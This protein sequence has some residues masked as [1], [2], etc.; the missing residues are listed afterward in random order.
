MHASRLQL[1]CTL[2][3]LRRTGTRV[4]VLDHVY[5]RVH[6]IVIKCDVQVQEI[7]FDTDSRDV[8]DIPATATH[9]VC[10]P[11]PPP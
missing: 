8:A 6:G 5:S 9:V 10:V 4:H 7:N 2:A 3:A 11:Y 1:G